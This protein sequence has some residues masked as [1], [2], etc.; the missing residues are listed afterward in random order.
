M[1][2]PGKKEGGL[3]LMQALQQINQIQ[4]KEFTDKEVNEIQDILREMLKGSKLNQYIKIFNHID[5]YKSNPYSQRRVTVKELLS[6]ERLKQILNECGF[7][8]INLFYSVNTYKTF[9]NSSEDNIGD[10]ANILIDID[11]KK[12]YFNKLSKDEF[13]NL[14]EYEYF[15]S[16]IPCP[17]LVMYT[18]NNFHFIYKIK[19]PVNGTQKAK[20]LSKRI[21]KEISKKLSDF[22]AD[23]AVNLTTSTR[24]IHTYNSKTMDL[25]SAKAYKDKAY[26]L[27]ELKEWLPELPSWYDKWK[28]Q[29]KKNKGKKKVYNFFSLYNLLETRLKDLEKI[30]ELRGFSCHGYRE[31]ICFLYRNFAIQSLLIGDSPEDAVKQAEKMMLQFNSKF[32]RPLIEKNIESKTRNV[33]RKQYNFKNETIIT[34]LNI[35]EHEEKELK[36]IISKEEYA[37]RQREY[38]EKRKEER[39]QERRN[40]QGLTKREQEKQKK[41]N[42]VKELHN[43]GVKQMQ[44]AKELGISRSVVS[45]ILNNKY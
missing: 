36:T 19:Y 40:K 3:F 23:R 1:S 28:E 21:Q 35:K 31:L 20:T 4:K 22:N 24:F 43:Q 44:I 14:M 12:S 2:S 9:E 38:D 30:Q 27:K 13:I 10:I 39:K 32:K 37:R 33:E 42:K 17:S 8:P 45:E 26:E 7:E 25:V 18:G 15:G 34:M 29:K 5:H 11:Y 16:V 6:F 41:I